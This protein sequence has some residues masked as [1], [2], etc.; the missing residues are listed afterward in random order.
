METLPLLQLRLEY[1]PTNP[2]PV[3]NSSRKIHLKHS[4]ILSLSDPVFIGPNTVRNAYWL[5][6]PASTNI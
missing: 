2:S 3:C 5:R 1:L 6:L 4:I